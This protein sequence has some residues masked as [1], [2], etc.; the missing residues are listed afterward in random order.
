MNNNLKLKVA[1][2]QRVIL[3]SAGFNFIFGIIKSGAGLLG[4]SNVLLAD[5]IDSMVD[6]LSSFMTWG[7][8]K[9]GAKP[10]DSGHPY[11]HGKIES[12]SALS[13]ALLLV[14]I[15]I[16]IS[17]F[18]IHQ[19]IEVAHGFIPDPP[20]KYTL[21]IL[22]G[23]IFVKEILFQIMARRARLIGS[24]A[25]LANAWHYRSDVI[26]SL[27]AFIG[28]TVSLFAGNG[29]ETADDWAALIACAI[30]FYNALTILKSSIAEIM[31][32]TFSN[33]VEE[34]II[35]FACQVKGVHS[36]EKCRV[37]KSGLVLIADLH[38]RVDGTLSVREGHA[39]S[40]HV[41]NRLLKANLALEDITVHLEPD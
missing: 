33:N 18:S 39:I 21:A 6:V 24:T 2:G 28:I 30:I 34:T 3:I 10:P 12:L 37:R 23:V 38:I 31:D 1:S 16:S 35:N 29:Y 8:L 22:I 9:Y 7:A 13:G 15:G 17:I 14:G 20:E 5:G 19:L 25:M 4:H 32:A 11:G 41:K 27:T 36:A 26:I 40:H